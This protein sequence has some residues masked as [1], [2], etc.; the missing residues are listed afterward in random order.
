MED[1]NMSGVFTNADES[2]EVRIVKSILRN[3]A[4]NAKQDG[5]KVEYRHNKI[6]IAETNDID[7]LPEKYTANIKSNIAAGKDKPPKSKETD[8]L[9]N[10]QTLGTSQFQLHKGEKIRLTKAGLL[11]SGPSAFPSNMYYAPITV[12]NI[13]HDCNEQSCQ[14]DKAKD[15][16]FDELAEEIWGTDEPFNMKKATKI[17]YDYRRVDNG[18]SW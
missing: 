11:F 16:G 13:N 15:H 17:Y 4:Y 3:T 7:K 9:V 5:I 10:M 6:K 18:G 12:G 1:P 8:P 2:K 14:Y